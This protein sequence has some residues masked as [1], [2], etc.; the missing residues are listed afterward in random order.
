M[1]HPEEVHLGAYN[2]VCLFFSFYYLI[3]QII[4]D[5]R[6][7]SAAVSLFCLPLGGKK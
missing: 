5:R 6:V 1:T 2:V 3:F 7:V 4:V